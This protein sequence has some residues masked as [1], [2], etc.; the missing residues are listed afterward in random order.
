MSG[1]THHSMTRFRKTVLIGVM[2]LAICGIAFVLIARK[3]PAFNVAVSFL[4]Y[5]NISGSRLAVFAITNHGDLKVLRWGVYHRETSQ[6]PLI[7]PIFLN[8][9]GHYLAPH[10]GEV[11]SVPLVSQWAPS[12]SGPWRARFDCAPENWRLKFS[13]FAANLPPAARNFVP[14]KFQSVPTIFADSKWIEE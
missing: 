14:K 11:I 13:W 12:N 10:V 3:P 1:E 9:G 2:I 6:P 7:A 5:T 8:G 4:G